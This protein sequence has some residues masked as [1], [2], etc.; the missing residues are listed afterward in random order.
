MA[1]VWLVE[2]PY[3]SQVAHGWLLQGTQLCL[4]DFTQVKVCLTHSYPGNTSRKY[5]T[6]TH[7]RIQSRTVS[8]SRT[9]PFISPTQNK[10]HNNGLIVIELLEHLNQRPLYLCIYVLCCV[11]FVSHVLYLLISILFCACFFIFTEKPFLILFCYIILCCMVYDRVPSNIMYI[12]TTTIIIIL[13]D[14]Q[15]ICWGGQ[16]KIN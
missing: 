10:I 12:T 9:M 8:S 14:I 15:E 6:H 7:T 4:K 1:V 3:R 11:V 5:H 16:Y 2:M 13:P